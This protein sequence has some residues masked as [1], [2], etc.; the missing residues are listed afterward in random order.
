MRLW[1]AI[2]LDDFREAFLNYNNCLT[3]QDID[4]RKNP[5]CNET[6]LELVLFKHNDPTWC[7]QSEPLHYWS[8]RLKVSHLLSLH[9]E[10]TLKDVQKQYTQMKGIFNKMI[11][12]YKRSGNGNLT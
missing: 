7:P 3:R 1:E 12:M 2:F 11:N 5:D 6:F 10:L 4:G 9:T 8:P